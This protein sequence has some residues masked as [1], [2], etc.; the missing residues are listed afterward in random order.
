MRECGQFDS[1]VVFEPFEYAGVLGADVPFYDVFDEA[2][3][4]DAVLESVELGDDFIAF[5]DQVGAD[6]FDEVEFAEAVGVGH[7]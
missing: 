6:G 4:L 3:L 7:F 1:F 5:V 2:D